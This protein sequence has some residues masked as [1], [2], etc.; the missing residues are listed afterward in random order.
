MTRTTTSP[1]LPETREAQV[2]RRSF[3][4]YFSAL[5]LGATAFPGL[6]WAQAQ[7]QGSVTKEMLAGAEAVTGLEFTDEEREQM[8]RRVNRNLGSYKALRE[9]PIPNAVHPA[10]LFDPL[11]PGTVLPT[12]RKEFR[13]TRPVGVARP[14]NLEELAF[15][16]V[17]VLSE[18]V[19]RR[20]VTSTELTRMYLDRLQRHDPVLKCVITLTEERALRQ[21]RQADAEI[22]RGHYRGPLHGIPWGAKDLLTVEGYRTTW[23]AKP[24]EHQMLDDNATVVDRL[25]EAGAVL[26]AKL[27][28]GALAQG[29]RW[30][31]GQT[32][33]PWNPEQ[34]SSGSSAGPASATVAGLVGFSIGSETLGSIVSPSSRCGATGLRPTFGRVSRH[35]AMALSWSMDKLGPLCRSVED[36]ALVLN[37]IH[38]ADGKDPTARDAPF[39]WDP[40]VE[41]S[42]LRIGYLKEQ[43]ER[44]RQE[45]QREAQEADLAVLDVL[46]GLGAQLIPF[47][48][49]DDLPINAM[50]IILTAEAG[51]AFNELTMSGRDDELVRQEGWPN[52]FRVSRTIPAVEYI[53]A[54]RLR[55]IAMGDLEARFDGIDVFVSPSFGGSTLLLTNLTGHPTVVVP[56]GFRENGTPLSVSFVGKLFGDAEALMLAK[57][58]QDATGFHKRKPPQFV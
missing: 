12:E 3:M 33:N 7:E 16:P 45:N 27:T 51:A 41:P 44:E 30:Y 56:N 29:D 23:G 1:S 38:G 42:Q 17:T 28:L 32:R 25:D 26:V 10:L 37:A 39:N 52:T 13:H 14:S 43:F 8:L 4:A 9:H 22:A 35:G 48:L 40:A 20:R 58:Y 47:S 49:P 57:A 2:D 21:A 34:G 36:C 31:G 6:L 24:Y 18:L 46:R 5:G 54:N 50:R 53:Q 19:R 11:L 15:E 55:T